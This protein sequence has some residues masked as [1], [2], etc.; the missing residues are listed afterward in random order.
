MNSSD[1]SDEVLV[2]YPT[3]IFEEDFKQ[4]GNGGN[5]K[6]PK[7]QK[8]INEEFS[9]EN[10]D[11]EE[12]LNGIDE[13]ILVA[14]QDVLN[15]EDEGLDE[16]EIS[17]SKDIMQAYFDSMGD[18]E[19]LTKKEE[20]ELGKI[21]FKKKYSSSE[22]IE[23]KE[24]LIKHNLRL[25]VNIA[26]YYI[27]RGLSFS[28][29]IQEGNMGMM[30]AVE[31][32]DYRKGFKFST[33]ATWWIRQGITRALIDFRR[34]IRIPAHMMELYNKITRISKEIIQETGNEPSRREI[35]ERLKVSE[36]KIIMALRSIEPMISLDSPVG[37]GDDTIQDFI[38]NNDSLAPDIEAEEK[39]RT[40]N[41]LKIL[42]TLSPKQ[43]K[44]IRL[45]F[46]I[47]EEK[48]HTLEE[49]GERTGITRERVRQIELTALK[50]LKH[51]SRSSKLKFFLPQEK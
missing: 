49:V 4:D 6:K 14:F 30:K 48:D 51:Y 38:P 12:K 25:V 45:R 16:F 15:E 26:K 9:D 46:G 19:V 36:E 47:G 50:K 42:K 31:K 40:N 5:N 20:E 11:W 32:F 35:A 3:K 23:A 24:K 1:N 27:G 34:I 29:L 17:E 2:Y 37:D 13:E 33:Y 7:R 39:E 28:D 18:I 43:E 21:L 10:E 22:Y 44:V 8:I 41:I